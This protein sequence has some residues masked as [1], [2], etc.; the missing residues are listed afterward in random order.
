MCT[1]AG[2]CVSH[3]LLGGAHVHELEPAVNPPLSRGAHIH[4]YGYECYDD[5]LAPFL[6]PADF[7][8]DFWVVSHL[9]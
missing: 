2:F 9:S 8:F 5:M 4:F 3:A 1:M 7:I 6:W